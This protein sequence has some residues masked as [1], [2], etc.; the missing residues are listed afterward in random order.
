M[1]AAV[2]VEMNGVT[3]VLDMEH[4][5]LR[6]AVA[7]QEYTGLPLLDW[8]RALVSRDV[9]AVT[10]TTAVEKMAA[11][12]DT[13]WIVNMAAAHWLMLAQAG[14]DP[15]PLDDAY[16]PDVL[17]FA[18]AF[19]AA[20]AEEVRARAVPDEPGPTVPGARRTRSSGPTA[21]PK[22]PAPEVPPSPPAGS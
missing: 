10:A 22:T 3:R 19:F 18:A 9:D 11:F 15:P 21:T 20:A 17:V 14:E 1:G 12:T 5:R 16:D 6:Q 4:V 8:Q 13:G 2:K 7:I